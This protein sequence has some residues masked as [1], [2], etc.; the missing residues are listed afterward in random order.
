MLEQSQ[1]AYSVVVRND[2]AQPLFPFDFAVGRRGE[3]RAKSFVSNVLTLLGPFSV[4]IHQPLSV[5]V[6]KL[7][8]S[9]VKEVVQTL[10]LY[11]SNVIFRKRIFDGRPHGSAQT[12]Y[13]LALPEC[14]ESFAVFGVPVMNQM[15]D[16]NAD[17]LKP[18]Q[19]G[20]WSGKI[21]I[22]MAGVGEWAK[23]ALPSNRVI[24]VAHFEVETCYKKHT[25]LLQKND[26][27]SI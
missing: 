26:I 8:K 22:R 2:S 6:V 19:S 3:I 5:D 9:H 16:L 15:P 18:P 23:F 4:V 27:N 10:P 24:S 7:V 20:V 14:P 1:A 13:I 17:I 12:F 21:A 11:F 25:V